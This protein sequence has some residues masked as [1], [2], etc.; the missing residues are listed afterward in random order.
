MLARAETT[1]GYFAVRFY[2]WQPGAITFG[3]NQQLGKAFR[4]EGLGDTAAIRRVTGGRAIF[5]D[6]S[7]LTYAVALNTSRVS[8]PQLAGSVST[9]S[10]RIAQALQAF[11]ERIGVRTDYVRQSS[12]EN[13]RPDFF[14]AAPCFASQA[15]YELITGSRKVVASAQRRLEHGLLQH[16]SLKLAGIAT[17]PALGDR[18][19]GVQPQPILLDQFNELVRRARGVL[20]EAFQVDFDELVPSGEE[21]ESLQERCRHVRKNCLVRRDATKQSAAAVSL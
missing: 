13:A 7:E 1:P 19:S 3:L 17:H 16:G 9:T 15:R 8:I 2:S 18:N 10:A 20:G 5:H 4:A 21:L 12:P 11:L 6:P 14:H